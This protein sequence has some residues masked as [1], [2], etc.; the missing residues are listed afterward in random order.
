MVH[1]RA[2]RFGVLLGACMLAGAVTAEPFRRGD[3]NGDG[4][5]SISDTQFLNTFLFLGGEPPSCDDAADVND[6]GRVNLSDGVWTLNSLFRRGPAVPSPEDLGEDPTED[7]LG[8]DSYTDTQVFEDATARLEVLSAESTGGAD[9]AVHLVLGA[10]AASPISGFSYKLTIDG[11]S[12]SN[13]FAFIDPT[14]LIETGFDYGEVD[15]SSV[16]HAVLFSFHRP[17]SI[18][19]SD[20]LTAV[21]EVH[22]C[23]EPGTSAGD[24]AVSITE[25]ELVTDEGRAL[26]AA[27]TDAT[28]SVPSQIDADSECNLPNPPG[29]D[30]DPDPRPQ[31]DPVGP[32]N[33]VENV[34]LRIDDAAAA[35]GWSID[36]PLLIN[37]DG[38]VLGYSFSIDF[39]EEILLATGV[40]PG[41]SIPGD[42][43]Y[44]FVRYEFNN[45]N[46]TPGN[47]GVDEGWI[48]GAVVHD[49]QA[50]VSPPK[51]EDV[52]LAMLSFDV[53]SDAPDGDTLIRFLDGAPVSPDGPY[54]RNVVTDASG[55]AIDPQLLQS[56]F[57]VDCTLKVQAIVDIATFLRGDS[58]SD[59]D[60]N[61]AD[62]QHSLNY[63]FSSGPRPPCYDAADA[64]DD[65]VLNISDPIQT[66]RLLFV[67]D[68]MTLPAPYPDKGIDPTP[69]SMTCA[70]REAP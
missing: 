67:D 56:F 61:I 19:P 29:P 7:S 11:V 46:N 12:L 8:C 47:D 45:D 16:Q 69:D 65:G 15:G 44:A 66:L 2:V 59:D 58:N 43:E 57:L 4:R 5:M 18:A 70:T 54:V 68:T 23:L 37:A 26:A 60:V 55:T 30:P 35:P 22:I 6:D 24:Y 40:Q 39:N 49:F 52:A 27:S 50:N 34:T 21:A 42:I 28:L 32:T 13:R 38:G 31:P 62:A 9:A 17:N 3:I 51:D 53:Q 36:L 63:L 64:N 1:S 41:W 14:G 20:E 10:R 25:A 48:Y 33:P